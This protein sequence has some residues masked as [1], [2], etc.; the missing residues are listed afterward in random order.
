MREKTTKEGE[1]SERE[2]MN[3]PVEEGLRQGARQATQDP[4]GRQSFKPDIYINTLILVRLLGLLGEVML[5]AGGV[6]LLDEGRGSDRASR[7][8]GSRHHCLR[9]S[10]DRCVL[11]VLTVKRPVVHSI[12]RLPP[13]HQTSGLFTGTETCFIMISSRDWGG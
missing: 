10:L 8:G 12:G 7:L 5:G 4:P 11:L 3:I 2:R 9:L 6:Y 1:G 13:G